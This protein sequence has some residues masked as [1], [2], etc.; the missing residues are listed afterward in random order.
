MRTPRPLAPVLAVLV[1]LGALMAC[2]PT[3]LPAPGPS[4]VLAGC[5]RAAERIAI[6]TDTHLDPSC[7]Y[8]AGIDISTSNVTLDCQGATIQ[9]PQGVGGRGIL[10]S[11]PIDTP[12]GRA[13]SH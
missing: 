8:T 11:T 10:I 1:A 13:I 4:S 2:K 7:T 12:H 9:S 5:D 6:T 3:P